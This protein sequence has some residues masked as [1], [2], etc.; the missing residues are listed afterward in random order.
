VTD[1]DADK[2]AREA[3]SSGRAIG[4]VDPAIWPFA[5]RMSPAGITG[6]G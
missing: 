5:A 4:L 6:T 1:A 2:P 3:S